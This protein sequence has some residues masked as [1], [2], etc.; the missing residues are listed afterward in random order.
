M[1]APDR[2]SILVADDSRLV[3]ELM[4]RQLAKAG[5]D[6]L[7]AQDGITAARIGIEQQPDFA[8]LD[9]VMPGQLGAEVLQTWAD[10]DLNLPVIMVS[11]VGDE[12]TKREMEA[13]GIVAFLS[14]PFSTSEII[15]II[16]RHLGWEALT[17]L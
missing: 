1:D 9:Q 8:I 4:K 7:V 5:A 3:T 13:K 14:K 2:I 17:D 12:I 6:V 10:Q 15:D 16:N 11:G